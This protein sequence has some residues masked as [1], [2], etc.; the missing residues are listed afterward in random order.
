MVTERVSGV[1]GAGGMLRGVAYYPSAYKNQRI[2]FKQQLCAICT[3]QTRRS[4]PAVL[5]ELT[6]GV[7]LWLCPRHAS[8]EFL[9]LRSGRD[10]VETMRRVW[11][12]AGCYSKSRRAAL[13]AHLARL[14]RPRPRREGDLPGSY[15]WKALRNETEHRAAHGESLQSI[16][17]DLRARQAHDHADAPSART[18]RRWYSERRWQRGVRTPLRP[19]FHQRDLRRAASAQR[20]RVHIARLR[21][22][23]PAR[24]QRPHATGPAP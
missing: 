13:D 1:R 14:Q 8:E 17:R 21:A 19:G 20:E 12:A 24:D 16:L 15:H 2:P 5:V 7:T 6:H 9:S 22:D 23:P 10:F 18:I 11:S 3:L 4:Q